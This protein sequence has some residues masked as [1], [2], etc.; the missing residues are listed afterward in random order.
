MEEDVG[1]GEEEIVGAVEGDGVAGGEGHCV[2]FAEPAGGEFGDVEDGE[3]VWVLRGEGVHDR[4]RG[5]GGAIVYGDEVEVGVL[6]IEER[7]EAGGDVSGFVARGD[8]DGD[9]WVVGCD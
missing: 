3:F 6:L 4:T 7:F 2:G 9:G 5:V 8:N 1:V